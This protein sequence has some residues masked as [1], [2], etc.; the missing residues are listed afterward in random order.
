M[1]RSLKQILTFLNGSDVSNYFTLFAMQ[2]NEEIEKL[3]DSL[4]RS[5]ISYTTEIYKIQYFNM[6]DSKLESAI[7][8]DGLEEIKFSSTR[9]D[10]MAFDDSLEIYI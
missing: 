2:E 1:C 6:W 8:A 3:I 9:S 4:I 10:I 7:P 5:F